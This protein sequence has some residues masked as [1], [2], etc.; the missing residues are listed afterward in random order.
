MKQI[1]QVKGRYND[2]DEF[3]HVVAEIENSIICEAYGKGIKSSRIPN[4]DKRTCITATLELS[5]ISLKI[6]KTC[7]LCLKV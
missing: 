5:V 3:D 1:F 7:L 4:P 6:L 2:L